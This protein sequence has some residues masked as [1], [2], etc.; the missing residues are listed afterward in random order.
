MLLLAM[1]VGVLVG[2]ATTLYRLA[3]LG[4]YRLFFTHNHEG[5]TSAQDALL[6]AGLPVVGGLIVGL[7][8]YRLIRLPGGHGVP[9]VIKAVVTGHISLPPSMAAKSALSVI[10]MASG[11]SAGPEG[12]IVEIGAVLGSS[13]GQAGRTTREKIGTLVGCGAA[14]GIAAIF[15]APLGGVLFALELILRDFTITRFSP[16]VLSAVIA[17]VT[18]QV[19]LPGKPILSIPEGVVEAIVPNFALIVAFLLL[20]PLCALFSSMYITLLYRVQDVFQNA[21]R[22]PTWQKPALGGVMVG[23]MAIAW[24]GVQSEGY[25]FLNLRVFS[26][27]IEGGNLENAWYWVAGGLFLYALAKLLATA[28]TLGSGFVGGSFAPAMFIGAVL[29]ASFGMVAEHWFPEAT[30]SPV[31]FA[32]V[33]MAGVV[34]GSLGAPI[35]AILIVYEITGGRYQILLPLLITVAT[36]AALT[37]RMRPGSVYTLSLLRDG[38]DVEAAT[39]Q[40]DPLAGLTARDAMDSN[41]PAIPAETTLNT[42]LDLLGESD[43]PAFCVVGPKGRFQG[44]ISVNDLRSVLSLGEDM[45]PLL[46]AGEIADPHPK[47]LSPKSPLSDA[48]A[49]FGRSDVEAI[50]VLD[51]AGH[52]RVLGVIF[53]R[54]LFSVYRQRRADAGMENAGAESRET[55]SPR[56]PSTALPSP[57]VLRPPAAPRATRS[58]KD[59]PGKP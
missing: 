34:G 23:L 51:P 42:I 3:L 21:I 26:S 16:V 1:V 37:R 22:L 13:V 17:S 33:G 6:R 53:R 57:T 20:G 27:V 32:L 46:L 56:R 9:S 28:L 41:V 43:T 59:R 10:T 35:S 29:G 54:Q 39:Q 49:I 45:G 11:G 19:L 7:A 2:G 47:W 58:R 40:R 18:T 36:A 44:L 55:T 50:P 31:V 48:L 14:S 15:N 8:A 12:P 52:D 24:P 5:F 38:F 4:S 30:P 25:E